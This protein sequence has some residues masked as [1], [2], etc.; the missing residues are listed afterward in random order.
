VPEFETK[1]KPV[2]PAVK[3]PSAILYNVPDNIKEEDIQTR[4]KEETGHSKDLRLRFKFRGKEENTSNWVFETPG[5]ILRKLQRKKQI[6][7]NW[8]TA[9]IREFFHIKKCTKCQS[10]G[11]TAKDCPKQKPY[12]GLAHAT[13]DCRNNNI[14][15]INCFSHNRSYQTN[16]YIDHKPHSKDCFCF[17]SE[18][19]IYKKTIDYNAE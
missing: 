10:Y 16:L 7:I 18:I 3:Y 13:K 5:H 11:H 9:I 4:L 14:S 2:L 8:T 15:C 19:E 17:R 1:I 6:H 12:C